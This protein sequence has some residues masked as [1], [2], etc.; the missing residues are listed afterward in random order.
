MTLKRTRISRSTTGT[1]Q[2]DTIQDFLPVPGVLLWEFIRV[3]LPPWI[4]GNEMLR[5]AMLFAPSSQGGF[6]W[7]QPPSIS[8]HAAAG[9]GQHAQNCP[10]Q[11]SQMHSV[12]VAH[13]G[14]GRKDTLFAL[15]ELVNSIYRIMKF[16]MSGFWQHGTEQFY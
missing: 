12:Y 15:F 7:P 10:R 14:M 11:S 9:R 6:L 8:L 2:W 16:Y 4:L 3:S 13:Q 5:R 1:V